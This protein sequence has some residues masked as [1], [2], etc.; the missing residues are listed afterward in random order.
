[1]GVGV[2]TGQAFTGF[3]GPSADVAG[4]SAVE[5]AVNVAQRLGEGAAAGELLVAG[6]ELPFTGP[7]GEAGEGWEMR[8]LQVKGR[9]QAVRAWSLRRAREAA[10]V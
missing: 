9:D 5:D 1:M 8:E 6:D 3:L 2:N 10:A 7:G 4:F